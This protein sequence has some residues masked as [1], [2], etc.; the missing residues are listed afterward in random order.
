[1]LDPSITGFVAKP[2]ICYDMRKLFMLY[3]HIKGAEQS[4][5]S[6]HTRQ[7]SL[8]QDSNNIDFCYGTGPILN[9]GGAFNNYAEKYRKVILATKSTSF[10]YYKF[11]LSQ[12]AWSMLGTQSMWLSRALSQNSDIYIHNLSIYC[13]AQS[14]RELY[15]WKEHACNGS[16]T[17]E[18]VLYLWTGS[19]WHRLLQMW[20]GP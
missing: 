15:M 6:D 8:R 7:K 9:L 5:N 3:A 17:C 18:R 16:S 20:T 1:M 14:E 2:N 4:A 11:K 12:K 13:T 19:N 10:Y